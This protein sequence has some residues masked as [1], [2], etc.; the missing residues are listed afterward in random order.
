MSL[1]SDIIKNALNWEPKLFTSNT[2]NDNDKSFSV[3]TGKEWIVENMHVEYTSSSAAGN[4]HVEL[5]FQTSTGGIVGSIVAGAS[6]AAGL[7]KTYEF[8]NILPDLTSFRSTAS[9]YLSTPLPNMLLSANYQVR[10]FD[11]NNISSLDDMVLHMKVLER[12]P[13]SLTSV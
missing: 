8:N 2:A 3:S 10:V 12:I 7:T 1:N 13:P 9:D 6:Q 5:Q 4:R 11:R